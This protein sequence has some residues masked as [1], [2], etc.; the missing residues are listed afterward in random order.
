[1]HA[2]AFGN[3]ETMKMLLKAGAD[4]NIRNDYDAT[5]LLWAARDGEK[6]QLLIE[7]GADVNA[8]SKQGRTPLMVASM[9]RGGA[10]IV[11]LMLAKGADVNKQGGRRGDTEIMRLLIAKGANPKAVLRTGGTAMG[12]TTA[13]GQPEPVRLL[14]QKGVDVNSANTIGAPPQRHG[15]T[16]RG[17]VSA[18]HDAAAFGTV[19]MVRDL[20]KAG[21]NVNARDGRGLTPL[22]FAL[23]TEYASPEMVRVLLDA[24]S[25]VNAHDTTGETPLDWAEKF[26]RPEIIGVLKKSGAESGAPYKAPKLPEGERPSASVAVARSI[27]LLEKTSAQFF[28]ESGCVACHHQTM[29]A[30]AQSVARAAA[31]PSTKQPPRSSCHS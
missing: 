9:R 2:A 15:P 4:V 6:A 13:G 26:G 22:F 7:H 30:T 16:N 23:A 17:K 27:T 24:G 28:K 31:F 21:A 19:E 1:M 25:E 14:I 5:A 12:M 20:I 3:L 8:Q 10:S 18:L 11:A 29:I